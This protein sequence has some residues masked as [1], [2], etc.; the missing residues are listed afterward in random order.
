MS[1]ACGHHH[2]RPDHE[3]AGID[4]AM[5]RPLIA[6]NGRL[7][8]ADTAELM[9]AL[10]LLPDHIE[11]SR[12]EPGCLRFDI[13]QDDDP[14]IW[15]L[16][17]LFVDAD[18]FAAHQERTKE[19]AWGKESSDIGRDFEKREITAKIRPEEARDAE[20]LNQ[21]FAEEPLKAE[22]LKALREKGVTSRVAEAASVVLG[23]VA[24]PHDA[25]AYTLGPVMSPKLT[26]SEIADA[27]LQEVTR[28]PA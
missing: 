11:L 9:L 18:A 5:A 12:A 8:C 16:S 10:S 24:Q 13:W 19:S 23:Y 21:L 3:C 25:D 22:E 7:I 4:V 15:H 1:C 20:A 28:K 26:G 17:E 6:L 2:P 14:L 27:L